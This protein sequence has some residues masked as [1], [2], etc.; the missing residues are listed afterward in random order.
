MN[1]DA[2]SQFLCKHLQEH[3]DDIL[4]MKGIVATNRGA[5]QTPRAALYE[6]LCFQGIHGSF[7]GD[8]IG[9]YAAEEA[10]ESRIVFIG[11]DLDA[12]ALQNGFL[13]CAE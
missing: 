1:Y 7:E 3:G 2:L 4:R 8:V 13:A 10:L 5:G 12:E 6:K 11:R 9:T